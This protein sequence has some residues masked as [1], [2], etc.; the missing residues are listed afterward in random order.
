MR[1]VAVAL[2]FLVAPLAIGANRH[3]TPSGSGA[4]TGVDW[5][6]AYAGLPA[7]LNRGDVYYIADGN[8][9]GYTFDDAA[10]GTTLITVKK[11]IE[12]DHGSNVGW[13]STLGDGQAAFVGQI[14]MRTDYITIDGQV[15]YGA[16]WWKD[17]TAYGFR[18]DTSGTTNSS[19]FRI[20]SGLPEQYNH[21]TFRRIEVQGPN[22]TTSQ[23]D[24]FQFPGQQPGSGDYTF[25][26]LWLRAVNRVHFFIGGGST[27][28]VPNTLVEYVFAEA[29]GIAGPTTGDH[30][31]TAAVRG[32]VNGTVRWSVFKDYRSTGGWIFRTGTWDLYGNIFWWDGFSSS[33]ANNG[34]IGSWSSEAG[35]IDNFR[36]CNNT[37]FN[38]THAPAATLLPIVF[39]STGHQA[40]NNLWVDVATPVGDYFGGSVSHDYNAAFNA[41]GLGG[42]PNGQTLGA[43]PLQA[44]NAGD[45]RLNAATANGNGTGVCAPFNTDM[46][47]NTRGADGTWDRGA[48]EFVSGAGPPVVAD[49]VVIKLSLL[50]MVAAGLAGVALAHLQHISEVRARGKWS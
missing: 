26:Y 29:N 48:L 14:V 32:T 49:R 37:F 47:G 42:E 6:N 41:P 2:L 13:V 22:N 24:S 19:A 21:L 43:N 3:V 44:P 8:Y 31:E 25:S 38:I 11:A 12:S 40:Q 23:G 16:P 36:I 30:S 1:Y 5:D 17:F 45:F 34:P 10:S 27:E 7:T 46:E 28:N 50:V 20:P 33:T 18:V 15:G 39:S 35:F 4:Q 9:G